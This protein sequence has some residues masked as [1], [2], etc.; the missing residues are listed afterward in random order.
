M[1]SRFVPVIVAA[2]FSLIANSARGQATNFTVSLTVHQIESLT[3]DDASG[4]DDFYA[5]AKFSP[6]I[7]LGPN[8]SASTFDAHEPFHDQNLIKPEWVFTSNV[9]GGNNATVE[10]V[11]EIWDH[12]TT[13]ADDHFDIQPNPGVMDIVMAFRP[14]TQELDIVNLPGWTGFQCARGRI[15][16]SGLNG[17]DQARVVF[18]V[19]GSVAG[20]PSGDSD[21]DGLLD[22]WETCGLDTDGD[23]SLDVDLPAMGANP[24]RKDLFVEIDWMV[25]NAGT[26]ADHTHAPWL[27]ALIHAWNEF[28]AA[29][30]TNPTVN[31]VAR[32]GGIA[33]HVDTGLLYSNYTINFD[34]VGPNEITVGANGNIDVNGDG[35]PDIGNLGALGSGTPGGGNAVP[36]QANLIPSLA[37]GSFF[38]G[39]STF[40]GIKAAN[41]N[42][43]R[44]QVFRY[45]VFGHSYTPAVPP[46]SSGLAEPSP[47]TTTVATNDFMVTLGFPA[48]QRQTLDVNRD[49]VPDPGAANLPGPGGLVVDG[50]IS[51]HTG[52]F[53]HELGHTL[54][55]GHG[56]GD[57]TN[58]KPNYLSIMSYAFQNAGIAFDPSG[59]NIA[60]PLGID[61]NQDGVID[62]SRYIYSNASLPNLDELNF[63]ILG[64]TGLNETA[65]ISDG[66]SLTVY[67]SGATLNLIARGN[68]PID[69]NNNAVPTEIGV[70][71][72]INNNDG[73]FTRLTGFNDYPAIANGGLAFQPQ[74]PGVSRA[75]QDNFRSKT[76][77]IVQLPDR[78]ALE[79]I[80]EGT[81]APIDFNDLMPRQRVGGHYAPR[82][83]FVEDAQRTPTAAGRTERQGRPTQS[84][85]ISIQNLPR[86]VGL[87]V[88]MLI[89]FPQPQRAVALYLGWHK[90]GA[91]NQDAFAVLKAFDPDGLPMGS[92][93]RQLPPV[94]DGIT[95][96]LSIAAI[97][98]D[99]PIATLELSYIGA[100]AFEPVEIDDLLM[101]HKTT[102]GGA[103][104][105]MPKGPN[106]GDVNLPLGVQT[107]LRD[108][109]H[110]GDAEPG[111]STS[112]HFQVMTGVPIDVDGVSI[113]ST[114]QL[115]RPE[116]KTIQFVAPDVF[117]H[118]SY[119]NIEFLYWMADGHIFFPAK[120]QDLDLV[121]LRKIDLA[122]VYGSRDN[123]PGDPDVR[124]KE[125]HGEVKPHELPDAGKAG[126]AERRATHLRIAVDNLRAAGFSEQA[127]QLLEGMRRMAGERKDDQRSD[128]G[129]EHRRDR[130][131]GG[132]NRMPDDR[133]DGPNSEEFLRAIRELQQEVEGLQRDVQRIRQQ[134]NHGAS[135]EASPPHDPPAS[136]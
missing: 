110:G 116:G 115:F 23:G 107:L 93:K 3:D 58:F 44:N 117:S 131:R 62:T 48:W 52:T 57:A 8:A 45:C 77:R 42:A 106:F 94:D 60:D 92:V 103:P 114:F 132:Y 113:S 20:S 89:K 26:P 80:C 33:L 36:E 39:G 119:G 1:A 130:L 31:G 35:T 13:S 118:P 71:A 41:F 73:S 10:I 51:Q 18:S 121:H 90:L 83:I 97:F 75:E 15:T 70:T 122:A 104:V 29:P 79:K 124:Q 7:G 101:C 128:A 64:L 4:G 46:N 5:R 22:S 134:M 85:K 66:T 24:Y 59:D 55:L 108:S 38:D 69:W 99:Q 86:D 126:E 72:D 120:K 63:P 133:T 136:P 109:I 125:E 40:G 54:T 34:A 43:V 6:T 96:F 74:A 91:Q 27:P 2:F 12:D 11:L 76:F 53:L 25:Q 61:F 84:E 9:T 95:G 87:S 98:A 68:V 32:P 50:L 129:R 17:D 65:G 88:P 49:G 30:V 123:H 100:A 21:G 37:T 28:N 82:V 67:S 111:H 81:V 127:E 56:G 19:A 135:S 112:P 47:G 102:S 16:L 14:A 105:D 78:P